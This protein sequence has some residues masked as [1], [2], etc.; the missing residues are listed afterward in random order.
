MSI[1]QSDSSHYIHV[2]L[3]KGYTVMSDLYSKKT[4]SLPKKC[5]WAQSKQ[6]YKGIDS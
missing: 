3:T 6:T 2:V 1:K 5:P 4:K